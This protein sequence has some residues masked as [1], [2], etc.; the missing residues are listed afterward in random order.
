MDVE[1]VCC[2][3][4]LTH[5]ILQGEANRNTMF[6][7]RREKNILAKRGLNNPQ[8]LLLHFIGLVLIHEKFCF[9]F[10]L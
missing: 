9:S 10:F 2:F 1:I 7:Y 3:P 4:R 5:I 6:Y 8:P